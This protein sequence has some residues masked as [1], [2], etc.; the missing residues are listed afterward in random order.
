MAAYE[1][2][3]QLGETLRRNGHLGQPSEARSHAVHD[4]A[5]THDAIDVLVRAEHA[6]S[7]IVCKRDRAPAARNDLDVGDRQR[8]PVEH[9][10]F[11]HPGNVG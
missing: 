6:G 3:L 4:F 9:H 7:R 2:H 1:V 5:I 10:R 11:I 8:P